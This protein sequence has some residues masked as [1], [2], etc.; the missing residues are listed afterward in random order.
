MLT[1]VLVG[2]AIA[3][4]SSSSGSNNSDKYEQT[5]PAQYSKTTCTQWLNEMSDQQRFAAAADILTSARNKIDGGSGLPSDALIREFE[6]GVDT[7]CV[8]PT[9]TLTDA[10]DGLYSTE[11]RFHP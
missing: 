6:G 1:L 11:P 9:M 10:T 8:V 3:G 2:A 7:V 4:C 5:W